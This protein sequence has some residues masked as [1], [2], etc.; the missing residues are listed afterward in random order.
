MVFGDRYSFYHGQYWDVGSL[1]I[2][3]AEDRNGVRMRHL[4][5]AE[6]QQQD[7][8]T[9]IELARNSAVANDGR[10]GT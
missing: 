3:K 9:H 4:P 5:Q 6:D 7:Q 8:C 2:L 1:I 10:C